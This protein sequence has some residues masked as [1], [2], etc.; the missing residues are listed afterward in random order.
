MAKGY[1]VFYGVMKNVL[2]W[3]VMSYITVNIVKAIESLNFT[4]K[5]GKCCELGLSKVATNRKGKKS[6]K[7]YSNYLQV[8][9]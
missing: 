6:F 5:I 2:K 7:N 4:I 3:I 8:R 9:K 1:A